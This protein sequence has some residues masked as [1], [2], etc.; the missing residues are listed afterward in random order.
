[1][2]FNMRIEVF[3]YYSDNCQ[4]IQ[5]FQNREILKNKINFFENTFS[6]ALCYQPGIKGLLAAAHDP[7]DME[8]L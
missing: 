4:I 5:I 6:P 8:A 1:M 3:R 2:Q 7:G